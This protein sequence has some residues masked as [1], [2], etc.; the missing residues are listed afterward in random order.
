M[1]AHFHKSFKTSI[2]VSAKGK[3]QLFKVIFAK[4]SKAPLSFLL[5]Y[6]IAKLTELNTNLSTSS[7][8]YLYSLPALTK[9]RHETI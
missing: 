3:D 1:Q 2:C 6:L 9:G 7:P 4:F 8:G 5:V